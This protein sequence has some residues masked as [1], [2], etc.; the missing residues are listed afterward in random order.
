M[1][2]VR[3]ALR[4]RTRGT[5]ARRPLRSIVAGACARAL[6]AALAGLGVPRS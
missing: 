3:S 4:S 6:T 5:G 1:P 2:A